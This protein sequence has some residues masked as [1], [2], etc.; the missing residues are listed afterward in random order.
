MSSSP[1]RSNASAVPGSSSLRPVSW[2]NRSIHEVAV[3]PRTEV[4]L[5]IERLAAERTRRAAGSDHRG[6]T[7]GERTRGGRAQANAHDVGSIR[8]VVRDLG[9]FDGGL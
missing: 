8:G 9:G 1:S 4:A 3:A 6:G 7:L 5:G 2:R